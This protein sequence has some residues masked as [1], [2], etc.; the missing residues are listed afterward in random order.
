MKPLLYL[1]Y[2]QF[3]N[4]VIRAASSP[5]RLIGLLFF[6][7]YYFLIFLRPGNFGGSQSVVPNGLNGQLE[8]P[9]LQL[10][11]AIVFAAMAAMS[12]FLM[13]GAGMQ[14]AAFKP[15]DVDILFPTPISPKTVLIFRMIRDYF[16][17]LIVP[18][19]IVL[20]GIQ[21]AKRGFDAIFRNFP[22]PDYGMMALRAL[23]LGWLL[24]ALMWVCSNYAMSLFI[25]R[26]DRSSDRNKNLLSWGLVAV[27]IGAIAYIAFEARL[28][29]EL[30]QWIKFSES[31]PIRII[32]FPATFALWLVMA[33]LTGSWLF[34]ALGL[35][36]LIG[37]SVGSLR[38]ALTQSAWMYDQAAVKG[39]QS[40]NLRAMQ[41][42]GDMMGVSA[43]LA[44][45]GKIKVKS[46]ARLNRSK[47]R[48]PWALLWKEAFL[49][50]RGMRGMIY[51]LG[52][53]T[54]LM[55]VIPIAIPEETGRIASV[56]MLLTLQLSSVMSLTL[57]LAQVGFIEWL[58]R[59]DLLKPLPFPAFRMAI[60]EIS[61]K[62]ALSILASIIGA[63]GVSI[64]KPYLVLECFASVV[65]VAGLSL[66][67]SATVLMVTVLFPDVEDHT[68][69]QFR[70]LVTMLGVF[71]LGSMPVGVF[72]AL[73]LAVGWNVLLATLVPM[74]ICLLLTWVLCL[75][76][77]SLY[78]G[79]NPSE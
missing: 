44:R 40:T 73:W 74:I 30:A 58:R 78:E 23:G 57:P 66:V 15:A 45:Q 5:K 16:F 50:G 56:G 64:A 31:V 39:F 36:A 10:V 61:A 79:Y 38:V 68:Q 34:G 9:P 59:V 6:L 63:V 14:Q 60:A 28:M 37:I 1:T 11:Q 2:S 8:F 47:L 76:A 24:I 52:L 43:E 67:M 22:N 69:R 26:S 13:M 17:T 62:A 53:L 51:A 49:L 71:I 12:L 4:G 72:L 41:R 42:S 25:N 77:G 3:K 33:P 32:F 35:F 70:G 21:P 19:I 27:A 65:L 46:H 54:V 29:P 20:F 75:I 7:G 48:G 55:L 18:I